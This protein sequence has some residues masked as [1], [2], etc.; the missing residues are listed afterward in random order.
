M[1]FCLYTTSSLLYG[2]YIAKL[3][4]KIIVTHHSESF[5]NTLLSFLHTYLDINVMY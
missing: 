1:C 3:F 5:G 4:R 2:W